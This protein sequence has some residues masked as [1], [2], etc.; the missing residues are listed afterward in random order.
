[1]KPQ[2]TD[3]NEMFRL[4]VSRMTPRMSG[5]LTLSPAIFILWVAPFGLP[6]T[7]D[8]MCLVFQLA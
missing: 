6:N 7:W 1:M 3:Q 4:G 2:T 5:A 8:K